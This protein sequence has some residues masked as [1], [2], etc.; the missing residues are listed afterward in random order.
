[1]KL[2][3]SA[4]ISL[5]ATL[6]ANAQFLDSIPEGFT[7]RILKCTA[8]F[9]NSLVDF[10]LVIQ[11]KGTVP[12]SFIKDAYLSVTEY[13]M[14]IYTSYLKMKIVNQDASHVYFEVISQPYDV[15]LNKNNFTAQISHDGK[16]Y[17]NCKEN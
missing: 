15:K 8:D 5:T 16:V 17:Y 2:V 13:V 7:N 4:L 10:G 1:M 6:S 3:T 9:P 11:T 12:E 14:V